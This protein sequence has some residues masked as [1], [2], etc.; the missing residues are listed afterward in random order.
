MTTQQLHDALTLLPADLVAETDRLRRPKTKP[1]PWKRFAAMAACFAL[2]L[3][4]GWYSLIRF[5][6]A[7]GSTE[8]AAMAAPETVR[9]NSVTA[10]PAAPA[11]REEAPA[12]EEQAAEDT[13]TGT[14]A[15][16]SLHIDHAHHPAGPA[17]IKEKSGWCGNM[18]VTVYL[19]TM[20]Y[21]LSGTH[22]VTLTDILY[23]LDYSPDALCRC[24]AEFTVD[25]EMGKGYQINLTEYFVR[26]DGGQAPLTEE[27]AQ[28]IQSVVSTLEPYPPFRRGGS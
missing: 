19:D 16:S 5:G 14:G 13:V 15:Q 27:Q 23:Y 22:A 11:P 18:M 1:I 25:T 21:T 20:H 28:A 4:C 3:G 6:G 12:E 10:A 24:A 9:E 7:G 17:E 2:V 26:Y 8:K